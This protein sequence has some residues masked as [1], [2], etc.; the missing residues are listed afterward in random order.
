MRRNI[1][2]YVQY[3][4]I[5]C[6]ILLLI[7]RQ[8][9]CERIQFIT[10]TLPPLSY[11]HNG[12]MQGYNVELLNLIWKE[13]HTPPTRLRVQPWAR[14]IR[15][16][17]STTPTC[18]FPAALTEDRKAK[19]RYVATPAFFEPVLIAH[20]NNVLQF[21]TIK[22]MMQSRICV[23]KDVACITALRQLGFTHKNF[24]YGSA[25]TSNVK[26]FMKGRA[27]MLGG[28][29]A[30][31]LY[32][33]RQL[34]GATS[35]LQVILKLPRTPNG[36]LFNDA[37]PEEYIVKFKLAM[38]QLEKTQLLEQLYDR[39]LTFNISESQ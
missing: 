22:K 10:E 7:P 18:I 5:C 9:H 3:A 15:D 16:L 20:N 6:A 27:P 32:I 25:H 11:E 26:K 14:S 8:G 37:V 24:D 34:G 35:A 19:Y 31:T 2:N 17:N 12:K 33:Y 28:D 38:Q 36:F 21:D 23:L 4:L 29:K 30:S 39:H 1:C 13:M